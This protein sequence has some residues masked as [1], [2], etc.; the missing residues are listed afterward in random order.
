MACSDDVAQVIAAIVKRGPDPTAAADAF[1][2]ASG[3]AMT[4]DEYAAAVAAVLGCTPC[5]IPNDPTV[6][7]YENQGAIDTTKAE[8]ILG[9]VP[10]ATAEWM[11][12]TVEWHTK[13]MQPS[14]PQC[15]RQ[16]APSLNLFNEMS[17]K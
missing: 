6:R 17:N 10:T 12:P 7:N 8:K 16:S 1:N 13:R 15:Q 2:V 9:F 4:I 3:T 5:S 11:V 14:A